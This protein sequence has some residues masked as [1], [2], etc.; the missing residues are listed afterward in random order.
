ML[1]ANKNLFLFVISF[2]F[3]ILCISD[4]H[5]F[6]KTRNG[7][8]YG[9][10]H[11]ETSVYLP[12][13]LSSY[14]RN[15]SIKYRLYKVPNYVIE[16]FE[17]NS[18]FKAA[19]N[20]SNKYMIIVFQSTKEIAKDKNLPM[21]YAK[22]NELLKVYNNSFSSIIISTDD[23]PKN[24]YPEIAYNIAYNDLKEYCGKFCLIDRD[25]KTMFVFPKVYY[26]DLEALEVL[27]QQYAYMI[28]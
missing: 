19:Y 6:K 2:V 3:L 21:F 11:T 7:E 16:L 26:A 24:K 1:N 13:I 12:Q 5:F 20:S 10:F 8:R 22:L 17:Y 15:N 14:L 18:D 23:E 25:R 9:Y 28:K 4:A 27:F